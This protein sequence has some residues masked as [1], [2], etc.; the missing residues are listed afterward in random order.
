MARGIE[1]RRIFIDKR[2]YEDF[3]GRLER[4]LEI[5]KVSPEELVKQAIMGTN[6]RP[7]DIFSRSQVRQ[8]VKVRALYCYLAKGR[9]R[10]NGGQLMRQLRLTPGAIS[11]LVIRGR[12]LY[13]ANKL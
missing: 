2:D 1:R 4:A 10:M 6:I 5:S 13:E 8:V 12:E 11:H 3:L 9:G 7:E